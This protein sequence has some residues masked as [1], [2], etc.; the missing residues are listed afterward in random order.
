MSR[1]EKLKHAKNLLKDYLY[2]KKS[3][4][5]E[6]SNHVYMILI[7]FYFAGDVLYCNELDSNDNISFNAEFGFYEYLVLKSKSDK[8]NIHELRNSTFKP[9]LVANKKTMMFILG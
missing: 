6:H 9:M 4:S 8:I 3:L 7:S 2:I 5:S 1:E